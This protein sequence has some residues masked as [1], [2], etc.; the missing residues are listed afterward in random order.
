MHPAFDSKYINSDPSDEDS[1]VDGDL[2][3]EKV[4]RLLTKY[5]EVFKPHYD[6]MQKEDF[7]DRYIAIV[8][9]TR[10]DVASAVINQFTRRLKDRAKYL[11]EKNETT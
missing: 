2:L 4:R 8:K 1:H 6:S 9:N 7:I 11:K 5:T 10:Y 3:E